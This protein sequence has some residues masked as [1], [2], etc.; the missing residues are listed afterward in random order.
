MN[1]RYNP[2]EQDLVFTYQWA[3]HED[4]VALADAQADAAKICAAP[5]ST[6]T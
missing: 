6:P 5:T 3:I 2:F 1:S 4:L